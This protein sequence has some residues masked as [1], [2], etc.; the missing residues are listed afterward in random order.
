MRGKTEKQQQPSISGM[1][2]RR[3][4]QGKSTQEVTAFLL[5]SMGE[6]EA[7]RR[8]VLA[9]VV[10]TSAGDLPREAVL[11]ELLGWVDEVFDIWR[12]RVPKTPKLKDLAPVKAAVKKHPDLAVPVY[13]AM[14]EGVIGFLVEFGGGP[15]SFYSAAISYGKQIA[16]SLDRVADQQLRDEYLFR[17]ESVAAK[18]EDIGMWLATS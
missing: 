12:G 17:L 11:G 3:L 16:V 2:V 7:F 18:A 5:K 13:L 15:D 1:D 10:E 4:I 6:N 14:L 9:W 8:K